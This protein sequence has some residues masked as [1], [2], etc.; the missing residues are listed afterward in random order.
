MIYKI[1]ACVIQ[2]CFIDIKTHPFHNV[3]VYTRREGNYILSLESACIY[4]KFINNGPP[5]P[6]R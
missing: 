3:G 1:F 2:R 6:D 5:L 4:I